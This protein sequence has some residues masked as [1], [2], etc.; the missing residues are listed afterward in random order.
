MI[1][2]IFILFYKDYCVGDDRVGTMLTYAH[3][4]QFKKNTKLKK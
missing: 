1:N 3:R 4:Q 2:V